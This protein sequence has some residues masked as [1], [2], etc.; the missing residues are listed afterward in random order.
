MSRLDT[1]LVRVA[2]AFWAFFGFLIAREAGLLSARFPGE[3]TLFRWQVW[4]LAG[5]F[6]VALRDAL[7]STRC[8]QCREWKVP[9]LN[10]LFVMGEN[11]CRPCL[12]RLERRE[13]RARIESAGAGR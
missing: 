7:A 13:F 5:L 9:T 8:R 4:L 11:L 1:A 2:V 3:G 6:V 10:G 12:E